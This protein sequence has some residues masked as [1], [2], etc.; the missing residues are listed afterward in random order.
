M[1]KP[2]DALDAFLQ[3]TAAAAREKGDRVITPYFSLVRA[4]RVPYVVPIAESTACATS[5]RA[6]SPWSVMNWSATRL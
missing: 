3:G 2:W 1:R 4:A 5:A 6:T